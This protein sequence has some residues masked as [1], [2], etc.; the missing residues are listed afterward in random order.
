MAPLK[1]SIFLERFQN[2]YHRSREFSLKSSRAVILVFENWAHLVFVSVATK[3]SCDF[4]LVNSETNSFR[5]HQHERWDLFESG[6]FSFENWAQSVVDSGRE[7]QCSDLLVRTVKWILFESSKTKDEK[8]RE[9]WCWFWKLSSRYFQKW[10]KKKC[11]DCFCW[12]FS[13]WTAK[14][15]MGILESSRALTF[16]CF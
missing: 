10:Q 5:E 12:W 11:S 6:D 8:C 9:W 1:F 13:S 7:K 15:K 4:F 3:M 14:R 16:T 2:K